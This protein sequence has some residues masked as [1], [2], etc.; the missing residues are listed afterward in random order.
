[1]QQDEQINPIPI[2]IP[3]NSCFILPPSLN[4]IMLQYHYVKN[5]H[6]DCI[7]IYNVLI[8]RE[9]VALQKLVSIEKH[10]RI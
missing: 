7:I 2:I 3:I 8:Y 5:G 9:L 6:I 1:M 4:I 10:E